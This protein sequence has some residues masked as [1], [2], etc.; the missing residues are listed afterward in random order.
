MRKL[1]TFWT[2]IRAVFETPAT[3]ELPALPTL[4]EAAAEAI[5]EMQTFARLVPETYALAKLRYPFLP[6][7]NASLDV[8][9]HRNSRIARA[10]F[11]LDYIGRLYQRS[12]EAS[13]QVA[14]MIGERPTV[15][16]RTPDHPD[17]PG[18]SGDD[19]R[20]YSLL[21]D[22]DNG[23]RVE[24][25]FGHQRFVGLATMFHGERG[26]ATDRRPAARAS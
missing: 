21:F 13:G 24:L 5:S 8:F 10:V 18:A 17:A 1:R 4:D 23:Q 3:V 22:V 25:H 26:V 16:Y 14:A 6:P 9:W 19:S 20:G 11:V 15:V 12:A 7:R 2:A